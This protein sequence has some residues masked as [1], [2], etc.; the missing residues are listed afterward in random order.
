M[1]CLWLR[2][3]CNLSFV[4]RLVNLLGLLQDHWNCADSTACILV[5]HGLDSVG[6]D[7]YVELWQSF[8]VQF[9]W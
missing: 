2:L 4:Y 9:L 3:V 8:L 1:S 5:C 6:C 7:I